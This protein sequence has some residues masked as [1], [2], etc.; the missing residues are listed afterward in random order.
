MTENDSVVVKVPARGEYARTVRLA[1]AE[2]A[3]RTGMT[4]DDV[5]DVRLAVDEAFVYASTRAASDH[6]TFSFLLSS[7]LLELEVGPLLL[8]VG[9]DD[10]DGPDDRYSRFIL[11]AVCDEYEAFER[12][13][14]GYVRL[15]KR[16]E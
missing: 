12:D 3:S 7:D 14:A 8:P 6:L 16:A 10:E 13:G 2:L 11:E 5:E 1:S 15:V 9:T 4:I